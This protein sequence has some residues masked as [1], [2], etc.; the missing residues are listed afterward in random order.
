MIAQDILL[1]LGLNQNPLCSY[2]YK[3][4]NAVHKGRVML[5][6]T[7]IVPTLRARRYTQV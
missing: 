5:I 6:K 3:D 2:L 4:E 7:H 1:T